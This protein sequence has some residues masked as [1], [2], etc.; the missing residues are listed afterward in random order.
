MFIV[1]GVG[2]LL[3][4]LALVGL[5]ASRPKHP[6]IRDHQRALAA[7]REAE[8]PRSPNPTEARPVLTLTDHVH[9]L[10]GPPMGRSGA[11]RR[12]RSTVTRRQPAGRRRSAADIAER[13]T[14][15]TLPT[16]GFIE[17]LRLTDD[18]GEPDAIEVPRTR[19]ARRVRRTGG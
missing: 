6:T 7:L 9:I 1:L 19:R 11:R 10:D 14:I 16:M 5:W 17:T 18:A 13:P 8:Q 3:I 15:A 2:A 4:V 12:P